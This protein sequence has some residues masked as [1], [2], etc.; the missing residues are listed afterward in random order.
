M[1]SLDFLSQGPKV[2]IFQNKANHTLWGGLFF[3]IFIIIMTIFS[4]MYIYDYCTSEDYEIEYNLID[5]YYTVE[6]NKYSSS[7]IDKNHAP[8]IDVGFEFF[9]VTTKGYVKL[10]ESFLLYN[11][12]LGGYLKR[13]FEYYKANISTLNFDVRFICKNETCFKRL[14]ED[15]K[16]VIEI[17]YK[18]FVLDHQNKER[19]IQKLEKGYYILRIPFV[20]RGTQFKRLNWNIIKY[21]K[22][23][24]ISLIIDKLRGEEDEYFGG[25]LSFNEDF[26]SAYIITT[27][28]IETETMEELDIRILSI[29]EFGN[30]GDIIE[31]YKRTPKNFIDVIAKIG[32]LFSTFRAAFLI[33]FDLYSTNFDNYKI[34]QKIISNNKKIN[35]VDN[36]N[37]KKKDKKK[38]EIELSDNLNFFDK[39]NKE[40]LIIKKTSEDYKLSINDDIDYKEANDNNKENDDTSV[41]QMPKMN[42]FDFIFNSLNFS[43]CNKSKKQEI[44]KTCNEILYRYISID[45]I[46]YNQ[47][48]L[49]KLLEDYK[50]NDLNLNNI[51]NNDLIL[52]LKTII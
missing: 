18:G 44:I 46:L 14:D 16:F 42:F 24:G 51:E 12:E 48:M 26:Q 5:N 19:P 20:F 39:E 38:E 9:E 25:T 41:I 17:R 13:N 8:I 52:K 7:I 3:T 22:D 36:V 11:E 40:D 15:R 35:Y 47:I 2:Y 28:A 10:N 30:I 37:T 1:R 4:L 23:K 32:A 21:K 45:H 34:V 31:I 50:W 29:I 43:K 6:S 27:K 33:I 49:E